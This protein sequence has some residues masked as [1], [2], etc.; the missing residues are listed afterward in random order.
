M[1]HSPVQRYM[2]RL[3]DQ[4]EP[5]LGILVNANRWRQVNGPL[6]PGGH[7]EAQVHQAFLVYMRVRRQVWGLIAVLPPDDLYW[8]ARATYL[9]RMIREGDAAFMRFWGWGGYE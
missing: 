4:V 7:L 5:V 3:V 1:S 8:Q 6:I 9:R 2:Y